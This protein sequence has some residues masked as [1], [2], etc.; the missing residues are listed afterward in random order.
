MTRQPNTL[1]TREALKRCQSLRKALEQWV[2]PYGTEEAPFWDWKRVN[3]AMVGFEDALQ[4]L[5]SSEEYIKN[6]G[7]QIK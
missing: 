5:I 6:T 2:R 7:G 4:D 1:T 3:S